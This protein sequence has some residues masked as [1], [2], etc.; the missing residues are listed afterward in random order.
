MSKEPNY[1]QIQ[2]SY[3]ALARRAVSS[4]KAE[5]ESGEDT[6]LKFAALELRFGIEALT[7]HRLLMYKDEIAPSEYAKWQPHK[8]VEMLHSIYPDVDKPSV[9]SVAPDS[10]GPGTVLGH[11]QP[12][13]LANIKRYYN[14]IGSYLHAPMLNQI[15]NGRVTPDFN[16]MRKRC[17]EILEILEKALGSTAWS[18]FGMFATLA[19]CYECDKP[20]RRRWSNDQ[21]RTRVPCFH[22]RAE[23]WLTGS[24]HGK[25]LWEPNY[26]RVTC[27]ACKHINT[28]WPRDIEPG[29]TCSC[30]ACGRQHRFQIGVVVL[31]DPND[32]SDVSSDL[33]GE[34][35]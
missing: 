19:S 23:Y 4:A 5:L 29:V 31:P 11:D 35:D 1:S 8:V 12:V 22:C 6:R 24:E 34:A 10:G 14:A 32:G 18:N 20:V 16:K 28:C 25:A 26:E 9:L 13:S 21:E 15:E 30:K 27:P 3:K 7:Y 2:A 17:D 33:A